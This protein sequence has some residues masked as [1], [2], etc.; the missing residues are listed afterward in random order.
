MRLIVRLISLFLF[1][2][3]VLSRKVSWRPVQAVINRSI[4]LSFGLGILAT[5]IVT[6]SPNQAIANDMSSGSKIFNANC[7]ACHGGGGN[8]F[9]PGKTL[10]LD[11]LKANGY[12]DTAKL[13]EIVRY[14]KGMMPA[15][16]E[17]KSPKGNLIAAKLSDKEMNDLATYV[18][19][20][21][22][23][24]WPKQVVDSRMCNEYPGC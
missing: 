4:G 6:F 20:Q 7:A 11:S 18:Q 14:G 2:V 5:N 19:E 22:N 3:M 13:V 17:F 21:A 23:L 1:Y 15:Y 8:L 9:N 10:K 16:G 24:G 12:Y